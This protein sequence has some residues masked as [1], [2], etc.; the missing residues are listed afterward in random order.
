MFKPYSIIKS[1]QTVTKAAN[2]STTSYTISAVDTSKTVLHVHA[3]GGGNDGEVGMDTAS[4]TSTTNVQFY[5]QRR[6]YGAAG[7]NGSCTVEVIEY[8]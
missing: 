3:R 8:Y 1:R 6:S 2:N 4:L 7:S 5:D